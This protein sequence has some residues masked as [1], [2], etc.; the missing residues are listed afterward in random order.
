MSHDTKRA[1]ILQGF[2]GVGPEHPLWRAEGLL[3]ES[4]LENAKAQ[5]VRGDITNDQRNYAAGS[6]WALEQFQTA[7]ASALREGNAMT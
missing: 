2:A 3:L 7:R 6:L 1:Q 4:H 5:V